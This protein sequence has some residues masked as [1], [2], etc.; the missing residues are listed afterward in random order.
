MKTQKFEYSGQRSLDMCIRQLEALLEG[1]KAGTVSLSQGGQKLW[2]RP[3]AAVDVTLTAEQ[4]GDREQLRVELGWC[5][6]SLHV[7]WRAG[8]DA[9]PETVRNWQETE[10]APDTLPEGGARDTTSAGPR[11]AS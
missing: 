10:S 4:S 8:D 7:V 6:R 11:K 2:L 3:G 5:R 9:P 1:L